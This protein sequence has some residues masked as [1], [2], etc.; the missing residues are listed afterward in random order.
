MTLICTSLLPDSSSARFA[1]RIVIGRVQCPGRL[2]GRPA[3]S[4]SAINSTCQRY[5]RLACRG[6]PN[7]RFARECLCRC[8][9]KPPF[10][11]AEI[12]AAVKNGSVSASARL[13]RWGDSLVTRPMR[14]CRQSRA[15]GI[16]S[17]ANVRTSI[18]SACSRNSATSLAVTVSLTKP[19]SSRPS[20][21]VAS[22]S[23]PGMNA[24]SNQ[25][26]SSK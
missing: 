4:R 11:A 10:W 16:P 9:G 7:C 22:I 26:T 15:S 8:L 17:R 12:K 24:T 6:G 2:T 18:G 19:A 14:R 20:P 23:N 25:D 1:V 13:G 3:V 5:T 21:K